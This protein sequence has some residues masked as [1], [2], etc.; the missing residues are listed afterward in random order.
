MY[1]V[2]HTNETTASGNCIVGNNNNSQVIDLTFNGGW[3]LSLLFNKTKDKYSVTMINL[4]FM[5]GTGYFPNAI[6]NAN[7]MLTLRV[8]DNWVLIIWHTSSICIHCLFH[9]ETCHVSRNF[10]EREGGCV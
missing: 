10:Q 3:V 9:I 5:T 4:F 7:G 8:S 6:S 2:P 1:D